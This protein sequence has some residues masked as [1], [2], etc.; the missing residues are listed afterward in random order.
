MTVD[1]PTVVIQLVLLAAIIPVESHVD[2]KI[3]KPI[4]I[5]ELVAGIERICLRT[6]RPDDDALS[7]SPE[8]MKH[9]RSRQILTSLRASSA[10]NQPET[11]V[12][13]W[14]HCGDLS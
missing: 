9:D 12:G 7:L 6:Q 4:S 13:L 14:S 3:L 10:R 2:G 5:P 8:S 1:T 11:H